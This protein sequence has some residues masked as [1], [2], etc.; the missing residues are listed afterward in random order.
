MHKEIALMHQAWSLFTI[1]NMAGNSILG[2][3]LNAL[4]IDLIRQVNASC[5]SIGASKQQVMCQAYQ[6][7][8]NWLNALANEYHTLGKGIR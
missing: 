6:V 7:I 3:W 2:N 4:V 5:I 8:T 1:G